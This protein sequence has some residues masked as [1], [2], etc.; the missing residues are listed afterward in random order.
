[1]QENGS[2]C[3]VCRAMALCIERST[4][5]II[6]TLEKSMTPWGIIVGS[7]VFLAADYIA[8]RFLRS[9]HSR[10]FWERLDRST[11]PLL[12]NPLRNTETLSRKLD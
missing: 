9:S 1:M 7:I 2:Y 4:P 8:E 11:H 6:G 5:R 10:K 12:R 3:S